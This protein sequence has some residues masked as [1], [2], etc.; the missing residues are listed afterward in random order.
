VTGA[1][2]R[3]HLVY[4]LNGGGAHLTFDQAYADLPAHLRS[5][6]P[7]GLPY[8]PWRLLE[9]MRICQLD[10]LDYCRNSKYVELSF[11][12]DYWPAGDGPE[13]EE[14][15]EQCITEYRRD[16]RALVDL[17]KDPATNLLAEIPWGDGQTVLREALLV[18][19]H[20]AYHLGQMVA[21]RT[22]L[23]VEPDE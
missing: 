2:L 8:T 20:N 16:L 7:P 3:D 13:R 10:I 15:W 5:A 14:D 23:G 12:V 21:V 17:V 18:A 22:L 11:P 1:D 4:L 19:D 9:H 6:K